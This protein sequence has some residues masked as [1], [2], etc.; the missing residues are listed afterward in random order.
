MKTIEFTGITE[1]MTT[2][3][4]PALVAHRG[5]RNEYPENTIPAIQA[6]LAI[7]EISG[8]EF[9]VELT[10][11][12]KLAVIHQET[13][14]ANN[15]FHA[16]EI[17]NRDL[18]RDWVRERTLSEV[19]TLDAGS[20]MSPRFSEIKVPSLEEVLAL[21]WNN[22]RAFIELKDATYWNSVRDL[23][24]PAEV[25]EAVIPHLESFQGLHSIIS[26]NPEILALVSKR[27][28]DTP[29]VLALWT[30]WTQ[31]VEEA[32]KVAK[33]C[34]ATAISLP[35]SMVLS[36][37]AWITL[38][39]M[40]SLEIHTYPVSPARNDPQFEHWTPATQHSNW[41]ALA[42]AGVDS[43]LSDFAR[44]TVEYFSMRSRMSPSKHL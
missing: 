35:H 40:H 2:P 36:D 42:Q 24:R 9:D 12:G 8:V 32:I 37:G 28:P 33:A 31:R 41:D 27:F 34:G 10:K 17:A 21:P 38:S 29:L 18:A 43:I 25:V 19:Q 23:K 39:R 20:W 6:A 26:F 1:I 13:V 5:L 16:V 44:E 3:H 15:D 11:D 4:L 14:A 22:T 30:E 7:P